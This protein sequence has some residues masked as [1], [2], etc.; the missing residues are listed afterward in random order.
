M[1]ILNESDVP[2]SDLIQLAQISIYGGNVLAFLHW[3]NGRVYI[4][5]CFYN[6]EKHWTSHQ[7]DSVLS[8]LE[9]RGLM[10]NTHIKNAVIVDGQ[11]GPREAPPEFI[12]QY[13]S[14]FIAR[15]EVLSFEIELELPQAQEPEPEPNP[16]SALEYIAA[17]SLVDLFGF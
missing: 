10:D 2:H 15:R 4:Q 17:A 8:T 9:R 16:L 7:D 5:E 11:T 3:A 13:W 1:I 12:R 6:G 14:A